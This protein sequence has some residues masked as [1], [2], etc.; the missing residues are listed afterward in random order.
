[1]RLTVNLRFTPSKITNG[2]LKYPD[3][4]ALHLVLDNIP[5]RNSLYVPPKK[6]TVWNTKAKE[7]WEKYAKATTENNKRLMKAATMESENP[8]EIY[9]IIDQEVQNIKFSSFGKIKIVSKSKEQKKL[10]QLTKKKNEIL[11]TS[12]EDEALAESVNKEIATTL[13]D[14]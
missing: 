3:H 10:Q 12:N 1:M 13:K 7:G 6:V 14:I 2:E 8:E 11:K 5:I 9:K 4:Y